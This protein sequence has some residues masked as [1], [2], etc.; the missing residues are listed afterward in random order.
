M[1]VSCPTFLCSRAVPLLLDLLLQ[2]N[3]GRQTLP[4]ILSVEG[5]V[6]ADLQ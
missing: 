3:I 5:A 4:V 2:R 1:Q 6:S